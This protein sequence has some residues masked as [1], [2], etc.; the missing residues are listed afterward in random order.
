MKKKAKIFS[1]VNQKGGV[2]K[3]TT[4]KALSAAFS[5][6]GY[7]VLLIDLDPQANA[8]CGLFPEVDEYG[9]PDDKTIYNL[10]INPS[11]NWKDFVMVYENNKVKFDVLPSGE[12]LSWAELELAAKTGREFMFKN[13][14]LNKVEAEGDYDVIL[15]DCPPNLGLLVVNVLCSSNDNELV[16]CVRADKDSQK[17]IEFL[18]KSISSLKQDLDVMPKS[19]NILVTQFSASHESHRNN[20]LK[21]EKSYPNNV[22]ETQIRKDTSLEKARDKVSDIFNFAPDSHAAQEY[23][24]VAKTLMGVTHG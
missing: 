20:F 9:L 4:A 5:L 18:F 2:S 6:L 23:M 14:I 24:K 17:G 7:K 1:I 8:T 22:L 16:T 19:C 12:N 15:I 11:L 10:L 13:R 21:L 3:T